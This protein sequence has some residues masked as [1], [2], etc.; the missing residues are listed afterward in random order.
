M[1]V[2]VLRAGIGL[3]PADDGVEGLGVEHDGVV[4]VGGVDGDVDGK[5]LREDAESRVFEVERGELVVLPH[6]LRELGRVNPVKAW[7]L[8]SQ[9]LQAA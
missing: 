6:S 3:L 2:H 5:Q 4:E 1:D 8:L 9:L 7:P